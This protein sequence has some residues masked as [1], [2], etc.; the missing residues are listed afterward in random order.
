MKN[1]GNFVNLNLFPIS[2]LLNNIFFPLKSEKSEEDRGGFFEK[3]IFFK[4][5]F[6]GETIGGGS[7]KCFIKFVGFFFF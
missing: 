7:K 2:E 1:V 4:T 5:R 3:R 6:S